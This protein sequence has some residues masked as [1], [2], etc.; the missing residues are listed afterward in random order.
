MFID[1]VFMKGNFANETTMSAEFVLVGGVAA[2]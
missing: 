2:K 1:R